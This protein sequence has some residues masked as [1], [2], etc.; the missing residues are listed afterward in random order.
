VVCDG[1]GKPLL[2]TEGQ[3]SGPKGARLMR[4]TLPAASTLIAD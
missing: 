1:A 2:L 3:M 4:D